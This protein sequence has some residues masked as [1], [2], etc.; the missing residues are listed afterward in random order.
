M[1]V[2]DTR[3]LLQM[4]DYNCNHIF[5]LLSNTIAVTI[6]NIFYRH[7]LLLESSVH[8]EVLFQLEILIGDRQ[9]RQLW[10]VAYIQS[11]SNFSPT[12]TFSI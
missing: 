9:L 6:G 10:D 8:L 5:A 3:R 11:S 4:Y 12:D 7:I 2:M 1:T